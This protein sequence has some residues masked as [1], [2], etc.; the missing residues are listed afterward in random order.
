MAPGGLAQAK[1]EVPARGGGVQNKGSPLVRLL[2]PVLEPHPPQP[3]EPLSLPQPPSCPGSLCTPPPGPSCAHPQPS[4]SQLPQI[5]PHFSQ[6]A[7]SHPPG[8]SPAYDTPCRAGPSS[9]VQP[10]CPELPTGPVGWSAVRATHK[11]LS[12]PGC[13]QHAGEM[14]RA[15][16]GI[17]LGHSEVVRG[18]EEAESP[19]S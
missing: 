17:K 1:V 19:P 10:Q 2:L 5:L 12:A 8:Y 4:P 9:S 16:E 18:Q 3:R 11:A 14:L 6:P 7:N 13:R 15:P